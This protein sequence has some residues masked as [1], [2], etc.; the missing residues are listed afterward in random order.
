MIIKSLQAKTVEMFEGVRRKTLAVGEKMMLVE[1]T[2]RK[3]SIIPT[4]TH[5]NEQVGYVAKGKIK[6]K[7]GE[8]EHQLGT[9]DSY[10]I[11]PNIEHGATLIEESIIIDVF[12]PPREDYK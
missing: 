5:P 10:Y 11:P 3:D 9:G 1:F 7:I 12:S 4:H 8:K 6:L 2:F